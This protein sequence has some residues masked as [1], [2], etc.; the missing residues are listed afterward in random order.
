MRGEPNNNKTV[1]NLIVLQLNDERRPK[2]NATPTE[3]VC[4]NCGE[5][6]H[7]SNACGENDVK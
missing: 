1:G 4:Y 2:K 7:K 5:K 6:G 3:I